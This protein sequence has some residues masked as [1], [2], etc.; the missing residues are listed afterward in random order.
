MTDPAPRDPHRFES[1]SAV[2]DSLGKVDYLADEGLATAVFLALRLQR[3]LFL[4]GDAGVGKTAVVEGLALA[5][6]NGKVPGALAGA[7]LL[8]LDLGLLQAGASV[9]G[10]FESRLRD[11]LAEVAASTQPI[12][13]FVDEARIAAGLHHRDLYLCH[14][15]AREDDPVLAGIVAQGVPV[16]LFN[17]AAEIPAVSAVLPDDHAG[18]RM[19]VEHLLALITGEDV[20]VVAR[21]AGQ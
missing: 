11:L 10:E 12:V 21:D 2:R 1:V 16:V 14:F 15:F 8:V 7:R 13:M 6:V 20:D 9:K 5:I 3:P 17:R 18:T 19:A 4:E